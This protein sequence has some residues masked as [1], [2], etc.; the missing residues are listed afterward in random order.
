MSMIGNTPGWGGKT[1]IVQGLGNVGFHT[2]RYL[3]RAGARCVGIIEWDGSIVNKDG[4]DP[5]AIEEYKNKNQTIVGFPG[6]QVFSLHCSL[7]RRF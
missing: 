6:A 5:K 4:I 2:L 1:F 3:H 7:L